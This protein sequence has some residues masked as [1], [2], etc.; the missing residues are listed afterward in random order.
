MPKEQLPTW[1]QSSVDPNQVSNRVRGLSVLMGGILVWAFSQF[2][3]AV[4]PEAIEGVFEQIGVLAG[5]AASAYGLVQTAYGAIIALL[6]H[7]KK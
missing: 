2:G 5:V 7:L 6:V 1:L 3:T 4:S